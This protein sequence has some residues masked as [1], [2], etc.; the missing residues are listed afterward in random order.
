MDPCDCCHRYAQL[1]VIA[2]RSD[3]SVDPAFWRQAELTVK[4]DDEVG[5]RLGPGEEESLSVG[6][7]EFDQ[8]SQL[9]GVSTPSAMVSRLSAFAIPT[10]AA[11]MAE[12]A[13]S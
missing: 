2:L 8:L 9:E 4:N 5:G 6:A 1:G 11:T 3:E 13:G 12:S 7:A 10:I